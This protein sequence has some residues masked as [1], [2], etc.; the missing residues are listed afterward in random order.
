MATT[1]QVRIRNA[2]ST[3][4]RELLYRLT[5]RL[6][7]PFSL[8]D[9]EGVVIASTGALALGQI[10]L[11]ALLA[12]RRNAPTEV[13]PPE[14]GDAELLNSI[15]LSPVSERAGFLAPGPGVYVPVR[16]E[17]EPFAVLVAH[18]SPDDVRTSA[19][20]AAAS[21]GMG[22][23]FARGVSA[24]VGESIGPDLA[25]QALLR[26]S[27]AEVRHAR[28]IA[29]V[30]GWDFALPRTAVVAVPPRAPDGQPRAFTGA[31]VAL[32]HRALGL[33]APGAPAG[34]LHNRE[35]VILPETALL[36]PRSEPAQL[37]RELREALAEEGL[38]VHV[39]VGET[40]LGSA[41]VSSLR[42]SYREALYAAR[43]GGRA[44]PGTGVFDLR[45]LG[46]AGFLAPT[47]PGRLRL[48]RQL[49]APLLGSPAV[50][51]TVRHFLD[52]DLSL[53][54]TAER[55]GLHRHTIR[56]HL[57]RAQELTGLDPRRLDD[58]VQLRL[59]MLLTDAEPTP[60]SA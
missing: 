17:D 26:G 46:P 16:V 6:E 58:A 40:Y 54:A 5:E 49:L 14:P 12:I 56:H 38:P 8:T 2:T 30:V 39:G 3:A 34:V 55:S 37:A 44:K 43:H 33:L 19:L 60:P 52:A 29:K 59:A 57:L 22:L 48:A 50:L 4:A 28:L 42:R 35:L 32:I 1:Q 25:I 31:E 20:S 36:A 13:Q 21:A 24:S 23:E 10:E 47:A 9:R 18:G 15:L 53:G 27:P 11:N 7:I 45:S 41:T 51:H